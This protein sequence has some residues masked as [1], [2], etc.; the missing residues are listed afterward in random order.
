MAKLFLFLYVNIKMG[1]FKTI[2]YEIETK[3]SQQCILNRFQTNIKRHYGRQQRRVF[4][5]IN[6]KQ[7]NL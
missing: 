2:H 1:I 6:N 4:I 5:E 7:L 3:D